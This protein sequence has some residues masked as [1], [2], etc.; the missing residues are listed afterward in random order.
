MGRNRTN[1]SRNFFTY[2]ETEK[3]NTCNICET[4]IIGDHAANLERHLKRHHE[5]EFNQVQANK[6][7]KW[8]S[9]DALAPIVGAPEKLQQ[10][11]FDHKFVKPELLKVKLSKETVLSACVELIT[12][13]GCSFEMLEYSGFKKILNPIV[14]AIGDN[15]SVNSENIKLLI[16]E[17]ALK[18]IAQI[19]KALEKKMVS[20][21]IDI[22]TRLNRSILGINAQLV[23]NGKI[24]LFTLGM[25]ELKDRHT[26]IYIKNMVEKVLQKYNID[27]RQIY[28]VT[29]DNC[30]NM[31][32]F[33]NLL[34]N[35]L[36]DEKSVN[37][38]VDET[39]NCVE[40][41][42]ENFAF[43]NLIGITCAAHTLQLAIKDS[44]ENGDLNGFICE[45]R[46]LV[47]K[48]RVPSLMLKFKDAKIRRPVLAC[49][50]RWS[51]TYNMLTSLLECKDFTLA[52]AESNLHYYFAEDKWTILKVVIDTL[53]PLTEATLKLQSE[54]LTLSDFYGIWIQCKIKLQNL[55]NFFADILYN[56]LANRETS[57]LEN[58]SLLGALYLDPR[59]QIVLS[60]AEKRQAVQHLKTIWNKIHFL[61]SAVTHQ[62]AS[63]SAGGSFLETP[64][65][66][67][68]F[69]KRKELAMEANA[70]HTSSDIDIEC[71]LN[72]FD[73]IQRLDSKKQILE[74]WEENKNV[75]PHLFKIAMV[76]LGAP[77]T[78][79]SVERAFSSLKFILRDNRS[80][81]NEIILEDILII[82][83]NFH[84][85]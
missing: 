14:S 39:G 2:N 56:A 37:D 36:K 23:T 29:T 41:K 35:E 33:V 71:Q 16:P 55:N 48:L 15:F 34:A 8:D 38:L 60:T 51:S 47:K 57:F 49:P 85:F 76:V 19:S 66:L 40:D 12:V 64:D 83:G 63:S 59:F 75:Y 81:L 65:E 28:S 22:A 5:N 72:S 32:S 69:L 77:A 45:V 46:E 31:L 21:K 13:N 79:V 50:T 73:H 53:Q 30:A 82:R 44:L 27:I 7:A 3:K 10:C 4:T 1:T 74:F 42:K 26:G 11:H 52:L 20:L 67:E 58:N 68:D 61:E 54:Q 17:T 78:Q 18:I 84:L 24:N 62:G 80:S 6:R 43:N 25:I 70:L 9:K